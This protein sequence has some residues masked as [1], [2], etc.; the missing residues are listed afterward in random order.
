MFAKLF[1]KLITQDMLP[2][3]EKTLCHDGMTPE[4]GQTINYWSL[5]VK[6]RYHYGRGATAIPL[7]IPPASFWQ[8]GLVAWNVE[9][10]VWHVWPKAIDDSNLF[11][12]SQHYK[13]LIMFYLLLYSLCK[14]PWREDF[15]VWWHFNE[16]KDIQM[17]LV[18]HNL[19]QSWSRI[20]SWTINSW[21]PSIGF[22]W[23]LL[24]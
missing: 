11:K 23:N 15:L 2:L 24:G 18:S 4:K 19:S 13:K 5:F 3:W 14:T 17:T 22:G 7:A 21:M 6:R 16:T 1:N 8:T 10:F 12:V 9:H 20:R